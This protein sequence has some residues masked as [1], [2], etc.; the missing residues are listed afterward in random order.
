MNDLADG[1]FEHVD[2]QVLR[3]NTRQTLH[4]H[5]CHLVLDDT[6]LQFNAGRFLFVEEVNGYSHLNKSL[7]IDTQEVGVHHAVPGG[8]PLQVFEDRLLGFLAHIDRQNM[9]VERF[10][11]QRLLEILADQGQGLGIFATAIN[12][13]GDIVG[14]T[15]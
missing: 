12:N 3:N 1:H 9:G 4:F 15:T 10:I 8:M 6:A 13:S 11:F 5:F 7:V 14:V 2:F